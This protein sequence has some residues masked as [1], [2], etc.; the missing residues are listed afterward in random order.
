MTWTYPSVGGGGVTDYG[1]DTSA[2]LV[3]VYTTG[4]YASVTGTAET[5]SKIYVQTVNDETMSSYTSLYAT[6]SNTD[7]GM[8]SSRPRASSTPSNA[9]TPSNTATSHSGSSSSTGAIAGGVVGGVAGAAAIGA[10]VIFFLLRRRRKQR[11]VGDSDGFGKV[12]YQNVPG[13]QGDSA[14]VEMQAPAEI[15]GNEP[16]HQFAEVEGSKPENGAHE[17]NSTNTVAELPGD[18]DLKPQVLS[19]YDGKHQW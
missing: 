14:G 4:T 18:V 17:I 8:S 1:C 15:M 5:I 3:N 11:Q 6:T 13:S 19:D 7:M 16:S 9:A 10:A 2:Y 12:E